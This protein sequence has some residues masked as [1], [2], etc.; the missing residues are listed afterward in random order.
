MGL[1][2]VLLLMQIAMMITPDCLGD[3]GSFPSLELENLREAVDLEA[4]IGNKMI[5]S[6][7][8]LMII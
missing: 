7:A 5:T 6:L 2:L 3:A 8:H 1:Y 4:R